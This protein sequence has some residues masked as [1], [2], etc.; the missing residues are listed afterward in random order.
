MSDQPLP[1]VGDVVTGEQ[2]LAYVEKADYYWLKYP[3]SGFSHIAT[4]CFSLA[5]GFGFNIVARK[6]A[7]AI[8]S[9]AKPDTATWEYVALALAILAGA[10]TWA[11]GHS[12]SR[13]T[14]YVLNRLAAVFE[15][16]A[17]N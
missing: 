13:H 5:A 14:R 15:P 4:A 3:R 2:T 6:I 16:G 8:D 17:K 10:I 12:M 9:T 1:K 11:V 7:A